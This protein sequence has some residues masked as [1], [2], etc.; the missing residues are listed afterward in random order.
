MCVDWSLRHFERGHLGSLITSSLY[1]NSSYAILEALIFLNYNFPPFFFCYILL[2]LLRRALE[3]T[4]D[5]G[6][7]F[8]SPP[9]F[10]PECFLLRNSIWA[11]HSTKRF[12]FVSTCSSQSRNDWFHLATTLFN[13]SLNLDI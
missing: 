12:S 13:L 5:V 3:G 9:M 4:P 6:V 11:L 8:L 7:S 2:H 10:C 1:I